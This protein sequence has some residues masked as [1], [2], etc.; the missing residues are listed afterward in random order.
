MDSFGMYPCDRCGKAFETPA[1]L[2]GHKRR[3]NGIPAAYNLPT[4]KA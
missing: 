2:G 3:C 1:G 4:A